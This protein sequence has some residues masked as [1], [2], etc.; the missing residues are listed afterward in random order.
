[1]CGRYASFTRLD[2]GP[3]LFDLDV[4]T[5]E[6]RGLS[7]SWNVAPTTTIPVIVERADPHSREAHAATWGLIPIWAKDPSI[8]SKMF[9]AR[10]ET[11]AE[12]KSFAPSLKNKRAIIPADGYFEWMATDEG[13]QPHYVTRADGLPLAF[14]GLYSWWKNG[15][16]WVLSATIITEE[17][18]QL[19]QL[20]HRAPVILDRERFAPWLD[21]GLTDPLEA[22]ALLDQEPPELRAVPVTTSV[23]K[24]G[25]NTPANIEP[26]GPPLEPADRA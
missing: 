5:D 26:I 19:A 12:K 22:L 9:N 4:V 15:A 6:V 24:V 18:R 1:M 3:G 20:H 21:P 25:V 14:A 8:G 7:P 17:A 2:E 16:D 11:L 13:K 23:G 10:S